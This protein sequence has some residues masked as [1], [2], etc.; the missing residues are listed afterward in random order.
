MLF[1][2]AGK[3]KETAEAASKTGADA[4]ERSKQGKAKVEEAAKGKAGEGYETL[5]QTTDAA[6][7]KAKY[8]TK[9][10]LEPEVLFSVLGCLNFVVVQCLGACCTLS[11]SAEQNHH[12]PTPLVWLCAGNL[13]WGCRVYS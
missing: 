2:P 7:E 1:R 10:A 5:K 8:K 3:A 11:Q 9:E 13:S 12:S 6:A 4:H